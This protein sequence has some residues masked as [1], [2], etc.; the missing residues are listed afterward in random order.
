MG[1]AARGILPHAR[2]RGLGR[3]QR[4]GDAMAY[5][6]FRFGEVEIQLGPLGAPQWPFMFVAE[7]IGTAAGADC[8]LDRRL[9]HHAVIDVLK[10]MIEEAQLIAPPIIA[11][12]RV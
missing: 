11:V 4:A 10:P 7:M 12:E 3:R 8:E 6:T 5:R 2:G 1:G 9:L